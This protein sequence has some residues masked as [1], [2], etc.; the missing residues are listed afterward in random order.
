MSQVHENLKVGDQVTWR[1]VN[2]TPSGIVEE[3][4]ERGALVRLPS[5]KYVILATPES[6]RHYKEQKQRI[7]YG[8][9][10]NKNRQ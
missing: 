2:G 6:L 7:Q 5:G 4:D 9:A 8:P 10:R 1:S 3:I